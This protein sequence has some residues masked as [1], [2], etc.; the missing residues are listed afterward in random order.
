MPFWVGENGH[1]YQL[2]SHK[3]SQLNLLATISECAEMY[4]RSCEGDEKVKAPGIWHLS[5]ISHALFT[6]PSP[7]L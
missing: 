7:A 1:G 6:G 2:L 3:V 5:P 4:Q